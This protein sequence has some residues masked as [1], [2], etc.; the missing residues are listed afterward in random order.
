MLALAFALV[1]PA[2]LNAELLHACRVLVL[3]AAAPL[4]LPT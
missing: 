1:S 2:C 4:N 3:A